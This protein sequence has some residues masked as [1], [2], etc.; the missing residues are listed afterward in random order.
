ME[1]DMGKREFCITNLKKE[2]V[3]CIY[4]GKQYLIAN[5]NG[6][7]SG[8][9]AKY[10][11]SAQL[12]EERCGL[13]SNSPVFKDQLYPFVFTLCKNYSNIVNNDSEAEYLRM[14]NDI[15]TRLSTRL[16]FSETEISLQYAAVDGLAIPAELEWKE[17]NK[18]S[19]KTTYTLAKK[20]GKL[21][22]LDGMENC[23]IEAATYQIVEET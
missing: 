20:M 10:N 1:I 16:N 14:R 19:V 5:I 22:L 18:T 8:A 15:G 11:D 21:E 6:S 17:G 9:Y 7:C 3:L 23:T 4:D 12:D 2:V 13:V